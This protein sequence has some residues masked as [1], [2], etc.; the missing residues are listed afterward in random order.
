MIIDIWP[1]TCSYI[2]IDKVIR[3]ARYFKTNKASQAIQF[4]PTGPFFLL[5]LSLDGYLFANV[6]V[7]DIIELKHLNK[8]KM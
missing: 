3:N 1:G 5:I 8:K 4:P 6:H 7:K 2:R